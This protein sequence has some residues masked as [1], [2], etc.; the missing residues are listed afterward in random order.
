MNFNELLKKRGINPEGVLV[1]RHTEKNPRQFREKLERWAQDNPDVFNAYQQGQS[2]RRASA[3]ANATYLASFIG[4]SPGKAKFVGLYHHVRQPRRVSHEQ[5][6]RIP[7]NRKLRRYEYEFRV[8]PFHLWFYLE[9]I[10]RFEDLKFKLIIDWGGENASYQWVTPQRFHIRKG[11]SLANSVVAAKVSV[12]RKVLDEL[13]RLDEERIGLVRKEQAILR[14]RLFG[15]R[16]FDTCFLC[17]EEL[18]VEL[19]V[20]AHIKPRAKCS[21]AERRDPAN[22]VPMCL[23]GCDALFERGHVAVVKDRLDIRLDGPSRGSRLA[24]MLKG[25]RS[26][27]IS[28]EAGQRKYFEYR[29]KHSR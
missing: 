25:L 12:S 28:V 17:G 2:G 26:R 20:A 24:A 8:H 10:K 7:E 3:L 11:I 27:W 1:M 9:S 21:D 29:S 15:V 4:H 18:P 6:L 19:L 23:L 13:G 22:V 14:Q 16:D 5:F